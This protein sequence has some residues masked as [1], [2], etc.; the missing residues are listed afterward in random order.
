MLMLYGQTYVSAPFHHFLINMLALY[1]SLS[2][3]LLFLFNP[4]EA[5]HKINGQTHRSAHTRPNVIPADQNIFSI[6]SIRIFS[7]AQFPDNMNIPLASYADADA[8]T[9]GPM[10]LPFFL[11]N[12]LIIIFDLFFC[13]FPFLSASLL[14]LFNPGEAW[15]KIKRANT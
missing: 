10:C 9:G 14:F 11:I 3:S 13:P 1:P 6:I 4:G 2:A 7:T 12:V 15:H 5:W 8:G